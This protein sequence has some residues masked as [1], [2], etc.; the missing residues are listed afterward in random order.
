MFITIGCLYKLNIILLFVTLTF[1]HRVVADTTTADDQAMIQ[2]SSKTQVVTEQLI[3]AIKEQWSYYELSRFDLHSQ[4]KSIR[5]L[6]L[7]ADREYLVHEIQKTI[8][9]GIDGHAS[10]IGYR[11]PEN[12]GCLPFLI[13]SVGDRYIALNA[14]RQG[15]LED[16]FPYI[17]SID[18]KSINQW[19]D[20]ILV[21]VPKGSL[22][23]QKRNS[24]RYLRYYDFWRREAQLKHRK[25]VNVVVETENKSEQR[26]LVL[27]M[28]PRIPKYGIWP[29]KESGF[30]ADNL[31]Y[32][33]LSKMNS[34]A[35]REI[36]YWLAKFKKTVG[37]I[38]DVRGN[39]GG[40]RLPLLNLYS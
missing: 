23:Y 30:I 8:A 16:R 22:Q 35:N 28:L 13:E 34:D 29:R 38:I 37:L 6:E 25:T 7:T 9:L 39:G 20:M 40:S 36:N 26:T 15:F 12:R 32:L 14:H 31:G 2:N 4:I 10:V 11:P 33:R 3:K 18:G 19:C 24:L 21:V 17:K 27:P 5:Q 1:C